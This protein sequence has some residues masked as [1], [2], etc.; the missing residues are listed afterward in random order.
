MDLVEGRFHSVGVRWTPF[1]GQSDHDVKQWAVGWGK[2]SGYLGLVGLGLE[3]GLVG[4]P[5]S[6]S[7][8]EPLGIVEL[9]VSG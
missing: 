1:L 3:V 9:D 6:Q 4:S 7:V 5:A 2:M 8:M